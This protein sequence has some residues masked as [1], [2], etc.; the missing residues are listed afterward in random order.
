MLGQQRD[1]SGQEA[2]KKQTASTGEV[3]V[4]LTNLVLENQ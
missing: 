1:T 2:G 4:E 3:V